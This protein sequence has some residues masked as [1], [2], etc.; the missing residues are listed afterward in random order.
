MRKLAALSLL[1]GACQTAP[2]PP[3]PPTPVSATATA[4]VGNPALRD[5][6]IA[7]RDAD[8]EVRKRWIADQSNQALRDEVAAIDKKNVER[9]REIIRQYGWPG[10]SMVGVKAGGAAWLIAQHGGKEFLHETLPL[11]KVA[12]D[13]GELPG[14][15]YALSLDRT[16]IQDGQNQ[17]YGSQ[18]DTKG[19]KCEPL[20]IDDPE[21]VDE[22]R[23]AVG[24]EPLAEYAKTL[25]EMYKK[26]KY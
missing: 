21:H 15:S 10:K 9:L 26:S 7:M 1:L 25:C 12:V 5:E 23:K 13:Q 16:R 24:L 18:F 20:P 4:E 11:M 22:R 3:P 2:S 17:V 8:Q 6:L 14:A 19:D